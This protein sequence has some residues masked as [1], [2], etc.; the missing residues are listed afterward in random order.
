V[1]SLNQIIAD[2]RAQTGLTDMGEP[3]IHDGLSVLVNALNAEAKLSPTGEMG[4]AAA[5]TALVANRLRIND[6][7]ARNPVIADERIRGPIVI[8]GL[9]RTGTTKLHRT[10]AAHP[11]IQALPLWRILHPAPLGPT[12][13]GE[14]D[15]RLA[16]AE[17]MSEGMRQAFPEFFAA[18]P[19]LPL[20][21]DEELFLQELVMRGW[22]PCYKAEIPSFREWTDEQDVR[23]WYDYLHR[24]L[25][26]FQWQDGS[27]AKTWL[28]KAPD[29]MGHLD[30]LFE[31]FPD[32]TIVQTHRDP[33][34]AL[35]S[36]AKLVLVSRRMH[37]DQVDA[38]G[39]GRFAL[40]HWS[41]KL[42][43]LVEERHRLEGAHRFVDAPY[44]DT[45]HRIM[46]VVERVCAAADLEV[47]T[48]ARE[49]MSAWE[50]GSPQNKYGRHE[51]S[52]DEVGFTEDEARTASAEYLERFGQ[53][54]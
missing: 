11:D 20:E 15:T 39:T 54:I 1:L 9:P 49:S 12:A 14:Q 51:Y 44:R 16:I 2:A 27:A 18:H 46:D 13:P 29:H 31:R 3:D 50:V 25:Q 45:Q 30:L 6:V 42:R 52:L 48:E 4:Q 33:V 53:L 26:M 5:L 22:M 32:A 21:P 10:L 34:V 36:T 23:P 47:S 37:S 40:E 41:G 43:G 28:L 8:V 35:A 17:Q 7:L 19:M 38:H 24:M